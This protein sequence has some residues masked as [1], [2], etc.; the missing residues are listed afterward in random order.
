L[1]PQPV[2]GKQANA[3]GLYDMLGNVGEYCW[4][5]YGAYPGGPATDPSGATTGTSRVGRSGVWGD[6][7]RSI[8]AATRFNLEPIGCWVLWGFRTVRATCGGVACPTPP[9]GTASC[10]AQQECEYTGG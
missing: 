2:K 5:W 1:S 3:W 8:R 10:N 4:D 6:D 7:A 9:R